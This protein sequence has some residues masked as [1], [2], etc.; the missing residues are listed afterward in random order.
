MWLN[1]AAAMGFEDLSARCEWLRVERD[2]PAL[3]D[4]AT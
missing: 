4:D 2:E 3:P 1:V